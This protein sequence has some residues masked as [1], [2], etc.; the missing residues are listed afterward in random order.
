[1]KTSAPFK[2][3]V[4]LW[5]LAQATNPASAKQ[6]R[7][8]RDDLTSINLQLKKDPMNARLNYL[9]ALTYEST[10]VIGT[11]RREVAKAGYAMALKSNPGFWPAHVQLGLLALEERDAERAARHL[12]TAATLESAEPVIF[13]GLARAAY[14]AGDLSL[15]QAAYAH[16]A[17]L[18]APKSDNELTT[19]AAIVART[20]DVQ[21]ARALSAQ[22]K[23]I[24]SNEPMILQA[25][26]AGGEGAGM[27]APG[28]LP[29]PEPS[30]TA[31]GRKMGMVD[32]II[33]RRDEAKYSIGGINLLEA[34][35][36]QLGGSLVNANWA[37]NRDRLANAVTSSTRD[38]ARDF[39]ATL[40]SVTYSLNIANAR[41]GW[42]TVQAQQALLIYD[43]EL[44]KVSV[45]S[46]L[47]YATDGALNSQVATKDDGLTLQ[48]KPSFLPSG[49]VKLAVS[50]S[51]EDFVPEASA[52]TFRQSVQTERSTTDVIAELKFGE[53]ILIAS[54]ENAANSRSRDKTPLLG[55]VPV[56]GQLFG[57]RSKSRSVTSILILLTLRPQGSEQLPYS[58]EVER[59]DFEDLKER[60][61][62]QLDGQSHFNRFIPDMRSMSFEA[63]NPARS[64]DRNYL[65]RA[66]ALPAVRLQ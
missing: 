54:G 43:G 48:I 25:I 10:S 36:L 18:R 11:E 7:F 38:L 44:S 51:L 60:L 59:K 4:L 26:A 41:D 24:S 16:A 55:D 13:Y 52:G 5:A 35:T 50:A 63:D 8:A 64:G 49:A 20:G 21:T 53:T 56:L 39:S 46:T 34:L 1:M 15:A 40:P 22:R 9:A 30:A 33:L 31:T 37:S 61:L 57:G 65:A 42:S 62:E 3:V 14:C 2:A 17:R 47:T 23:L 66:G 28:D 45:G 32:I 27:A 12:M 58:N 29:T 6:A 19:G